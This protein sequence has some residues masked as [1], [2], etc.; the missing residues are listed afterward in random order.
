MLLEALEA[1]DCPF[2]CDAV[3][4]NVYAVPAVRPV[5]VIGLDAPEAVNPLGDEVTV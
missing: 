1:R 3:T 4:V 5:T 2:A